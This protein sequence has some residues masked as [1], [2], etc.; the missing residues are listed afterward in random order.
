[1]TTNTKSGIPNDEGGRL[2]EAGRSAP[3]RLPRQSGRFAEPSR[4]SLGRGTRLGRAI[5]PASASAGSGSSKPITGET[6][7]LT[8][9]ADRFPRGFTAREIAARIDDADDLIGDGDAQL[10]RALEGVGYW[11]PRV[12][13][14]VMGQWLTA[15]L[16]RPAAGLVLRLGKLRDGYRRYHVVT[17][18]ASASA[19]GTQKL[20][21]SAATRAAVD[22][23]V[24]PVGT[25]VGE[26]S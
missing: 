15:L 19:F 5:S 14:A 20:V 8:L 7:L 16:D 23:S 12:N 18:A 2:A 3:S 6:A 13:G 10:K 21:H 1:M 24:P 17:E 9:L 11:R 4:E 26:R 25:D 22:K